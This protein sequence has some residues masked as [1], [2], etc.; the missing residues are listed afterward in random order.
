MSDAVA[1]HL[2]HLSTARNEVKES[3]AH[4][5]KVLNAATRNVP[6]GSRMMHQFDH[7]RQY[8]RLA[9]YHSLPSALLSRCVHYQRAQVA[10]DSYVQMQRLA[11]IIRASSPCTDSVRQMMNREHLALAVTHQRRHCIYNVGQSLKLAATD[12]TP[13]W[14]HHHNQHNQ[15]QQQQSV[16]GVRQ[17]CLTSTTQSESNDRRHGNEF[18]GHQVTSGQTGQ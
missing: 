1:N 3:W 5:N 16:A 6:V 13:C 8:H 7:P 17:S 15:Q 2:N 18:T 4:R 11:A 10:V 9:P 14:Q 12:L